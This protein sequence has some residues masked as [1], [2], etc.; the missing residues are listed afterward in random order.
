MKKFSLG[1]R[2]KVI[3]LASF[4]LILPWLGYEY[5]WEMEKFLRQGQ[6]QT[7][8]GTTRAV[9]TALHERPKLFN[10]Q[11]SFLQ[12]VDAGKDL[13]AY[14]IKQ[15]IQIDGF[16]DD[17]KA[18]KSQS[19][20]YGPEYVRFQADKNTNNPISF[21]HM[22]GKKDGYL[23]GYFQVN[24][25]YPVFRQKNAR[26]IDKNDH[27]IIALSDPS[28]ILRRYVISVH[29]SGWFNAFLQPDPGSD[30]SRLQREKRIQGYWKETEAGYNIEFRL[31]LDMLGN[32]LGF[33]LHTV[34]DKN[35]RRVNNIIA[36]SNTRDLQ[37][38]G[39]VLVPSPEIERII[40]GM[41][42]TRS[43]IWVVDRHQRVL[44]KAGDIRKADGVWAPDYQEQVSEDSLWYQLQDKLLAPLY[45][46][47][48][49]RPPHDFIDDLS[50]STQLNSKFIK[51]AL[52][53]KSQS[54]WRLTD[55]NKAMILSAAHPIMVGD[56]VMG[57]VVAEET[58]NGIRTLRNKALE[59]L[60]NVLL[61][62][63]VVGTLLLFVFASNIASRI[64]KLRDQAD[65]AID[66]Q[67][68]ILAPFTPSKSG[69][70]I[71]DLSR[72]LSDMVN[73]LGQYH[74]YLENLSSRLSHELRTPVAVVRSS[75]ENLSQLPQNE[76]SQKYINR[77][78]KGIIR[79]NRILTSMSEATR[80]E[81]SLQSSDKEYFPLNEL[82]EGCIQGYQMTYS[83]YKFELYKSDK[84]L[85][86]HAEPDF[87][88]QLFDKLISNAM[89]FSEQ[90]NAIHISLKQQGDSAL[91][92]VANIGPLLPENM[93]DEL[94]NSMVSVR[95]KNSKD[96]T[97]LGLGLFIAKMITE[98]HQGKIS[99]RNRE[100][101]LGVEV[102][103][104]LPINKG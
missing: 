84:I 92:T 69:D 14:T 3:L 75:L 97:H 64:R 29:K 79:L 103:I 68:R 81:Q 24:D 89:E 42:H 76:E 87:I 18:N 21:T 1:L 70:E 2:S 6:E 102:L 7:L 61:S 98:F 57:I 50:D 91:L 95:A 19:L 71:G 58:T 96:K 9:A 20:F 54:S 80:I 38:L 26:Q 99:I 67:G 47:F 30:I 53:G 100:D 43:R 25:K 86:I 77:A 12:Q 52:N 63:I 23:Y 88:V 48:L 56:K 94:L 31:P 40:K 45:D 4:L 41:S 27:L 28:G 82:V 32:K 13:Y 46:L 73:R 37:Q 35:K 59:K 15:A 34:S 10:S 22:V 51:D 36:T 17:W 101:N 55:D 49:S 85:P 72:G 66:D 83:E 33:A 62:I 8:I 11:A 93:S 90:E 5:V 16:L 39:T 104:S 60:F 44:A 78:E 65:N 74:H